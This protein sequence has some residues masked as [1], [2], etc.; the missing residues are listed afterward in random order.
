MY[1]DSAY[2][3]KFYLKEPDSPRI[4]EALAA[5]PTRVSSMLAIPEVV[6]A[7]HRHLHEGHHSQE[8]FVALKNRFL[9]DVDAD[10]WR[11]IPVGDGLLRRLAGTIGAAPGKLFLRAGSALHLATAS[12]Y[13]ETEIWSNDRHLLAAAP[14]FGLAGRSI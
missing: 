5:F 13:A 2:I 1:L 8:D 4:R 7:F 3:A 9:Q 12:A 6:C 14:Y 11:L 10:V